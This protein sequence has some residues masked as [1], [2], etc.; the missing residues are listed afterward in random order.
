MVEEANP[1]LNGTD[2]FDGGGESRATGVVSTRLLIFEDKGDNENPRIFDTSLSDGSILSLADDD[3]SLVFRVKNRIRRI[4]VHLPLERFMRFL[5]SFAGRQSSSER[6]WAARF[7]S[8][9]PHQERP[10]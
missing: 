8:I 3:G 10:V 4:S 1:S 5:V 2:G 9:M 6:T 7:L